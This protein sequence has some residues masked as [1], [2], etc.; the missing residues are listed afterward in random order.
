MKTYQIGYYKKNKDE[1]GNFLL[2][3][4]WVRIGE[5]LRDKKRA[6]KLVFW[7]RKRGVMAFA[8]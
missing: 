6:F 1:H 5:G 2:V 8:F 4:N 7:L 3:R